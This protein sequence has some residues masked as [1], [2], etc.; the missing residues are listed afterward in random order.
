[1]SYD[2]V[3]GDDK[4]NLQRLAAEND[5]KFFS[6]S[7]VFAQGGYLCGVPKKAESSFH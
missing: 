6:G 2:H 1:M 7:A 4:M 5:G 3:A